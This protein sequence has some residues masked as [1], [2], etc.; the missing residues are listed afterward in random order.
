MF[1]F[2]NAKS[3]L[4]HLQITELSVRVKKNSLNWKKT[5]A[6]N[7]KPIKTL[8]DKKCAFQKNGK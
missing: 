4:V 1:F 8:H 7:S 2:K 6:L 3:D 5:H